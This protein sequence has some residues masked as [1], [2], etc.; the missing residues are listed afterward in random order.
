MKRLPPVALLAA[1]AACGDASADVSSTVRDSAGIR[2]VESTAPA[3]K[4]GQA[5]RL[6]AAPTLVIGGDEGDAATQFGEITSAVR[7]PGG[8]IAVSDGQAGDIR[9]FT[10]DGRHLRTLAKKASGPGEISGFATVFPLRGDSVAAWDLMAGRLSVFS[11]GSGFARAVTVHRSGPA[12]PG[13]DGIFP[14]GSLLVND[15]MVMVMSSSSAARRDTAR[16]FRYSAD[17]AR[18]DTVARF[19]GTEMITVVGEGS[20]SRAPVPFGGKS[21]RRVH[22][23]H[24]VFADNA[25]GDVEVREPTGRVL[26]IFRGSGFRPVP[27]TDEEVR[28]H[29][30]REL[31]ESEARFR[32]MQ[33][34]LNEAMPYPRMKSAFDDLR[35]DRAGHV[36]LA[37]H[38]APGADAVPWNV[39]DAEGRW[40]G[41]VPVPAGLRVLEIGAD[42][43]LA[44]GKDEM[45]VQRVELYRLEKPAGE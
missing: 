2:I 45:D 15:Q 21:F 6:S 24:F 33:E 13:L 27:V 36:W 28:A 20:A 23:G 31:E 12:I 18:H 14:D 5:W 10:A 41:T 37:G 25:R 9:L 7:L 11:P 44:A 22:G 29:K 35:V 17:A 1:L 39:L 42:Y 16:L 40:L 34:R 19:A 4:E 38:A 26:R 30:A 43:L 8:E 3:W 32:P